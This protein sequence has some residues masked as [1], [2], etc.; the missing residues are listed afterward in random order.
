LRK[1][2]AYDYLDVAELRQNLKDW[3]IMS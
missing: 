2:F 3:E 1:A